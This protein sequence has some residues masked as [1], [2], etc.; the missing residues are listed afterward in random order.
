MRGKNVTKPKKNGSVICDFDLCHR[1]TLQINAQ[2][3]SQQRKRANLQDAWDA[4]KMMTSLGRW[5]DI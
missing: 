1:G 4:N 3:K 5:A 2:N